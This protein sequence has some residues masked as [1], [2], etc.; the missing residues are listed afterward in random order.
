MR[1]LQAII[2][3][4]GRACISIIFI[5][6]AFHKI[7]DWQATQRGLVGLLCDWQGY[8]SYSIELQRFFGA[9][10]SW[11]PTILGVVTAIELIGGFMVLLGLKPRLG[12]FLLLIFFIPTTILFHQFWFLE[13]IRREMQITIFLKNIAIMGALFLIVA[14]KGKV[15]KK[16]SMPSIP[17][18]SPNLDE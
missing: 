3:F 15:E 11:V 5:S 4:L 14:F 17:L 12:A 16:R 1:A 13:G 2:A 18:E 10:L 8:V 6:S 9:L 7:I